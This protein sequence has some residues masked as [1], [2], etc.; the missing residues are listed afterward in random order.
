MSEQNIVKAKDIK[1]K[2]SL[3][4]FKEEQNVTF[5]KMYKSKKQETVKPNEI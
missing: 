5:F 3:F 1:V 2:G 4:I